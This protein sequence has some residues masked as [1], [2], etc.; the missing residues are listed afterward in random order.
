MLILL[1]TLAVIAMAI[2]I[3]KDADAIWIVILGVALFI[4]ICA[5]I[6]TT[7]DVVKSTVIDDR[8]SMY[9]EENTK[10]EADVSTVV[11]SYINHELEVFD[12]SDTESL[13]VL[14]QMYPELKSDTLVKN[15]IDVYISNN[16]KIKSLREAKINYELSKW[17]LYFN[18]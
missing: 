9:Q 11:C 2:L 10:I 4:I 12:R 16:N 14:I 18:L 8:I 17:W 13:I 5:T 1:L 6:N 7:V 15:Q 3:R